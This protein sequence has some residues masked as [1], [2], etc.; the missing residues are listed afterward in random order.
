MPEN[1]VSPF[2]IVEAALTAKIGTAS[3][4]GFTQ[5]VSNVLATP[6]TTS[7]TWKGMSK[8]AIFRFISAAVW[9]LQMGFAQDWSTTGLS[10]FLYDNEGKECVFSFAPVAGG[11]G[12]SVTVT[13]TP[14]AYGGAVDATGE[15]TVTMPVK[16]RPTLLTAVSPV[17]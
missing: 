7:S 12:F 5:H 2:N 4:V 1:P 10:R 3:A 15:A 14:G 16:G 13:I 6:T 17:A 9:D 11:A 8:A